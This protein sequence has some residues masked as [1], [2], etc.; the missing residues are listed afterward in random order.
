MTDNIDIIDILSWFPFS[1]YRQLM[2]RYGLTPADYS[3]TILDPIKPST[4]TIGGFFTNLT[5]H[6]ES[7][8]GKFAI[9]A[10]EPIVKIGSNY[11]E[12]YAPGYTDPIK[13]P[14]TSK[15]GRKPKPKKEKTR[16]KGNGKYFNSQ[17]TM[18]VR[19]PS[20]EGKLYKFKV[21]RTGMFQ[22]PGV[23]EGDMCDIEQP[24]LILQKRLSTLFNTN[25]EVIDRSVQ[26]RNCKT[27]LS[28]LKLSINTDKLGKLI[29]FEKN[30]NNEMLIS[31]VE[32]MNAQNSNK[33]V[34]KF[35]RPT[36]DK[37]NKNTTLK[38][39]KQK[40][41]IEG[42]VGKEG[43]D[44]IY[45]WLNDFMLDNYYRVIYDPQAPKEESDSSDTDQ[46]DDS[47]ADNLA[48]IHQRDYDPYAF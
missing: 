48:V 23:L 10:Q 35:S 37:A 18:V 42:A 17:I 14:K 25:V 32:Y 2:S 31:K 24:L 11:G 36:K 39:L 30:S 28:D 21:F 34:V 6:E 3:G 7:D 27:V 19:S 5:L 12:H 22:V 8:I 47:D 46:D 40:I 15:R 45:Y 44:D 4:I 1:V 29:E 20:R 26:M 16:S 13:P 43:V 33:I 9:L 41:N 38:I